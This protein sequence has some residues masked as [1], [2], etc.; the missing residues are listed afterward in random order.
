V[1]AIDRDRD[2]IE[3]ELRATEQRGR[4]TAEGQAT[5]AVNDWGAAE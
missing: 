3:I 1:T 5:V 2:E 4:V